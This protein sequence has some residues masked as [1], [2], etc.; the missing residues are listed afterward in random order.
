MFISTIQLL[1]AHNLN[2]KHQILWNLLKFSIDNFYNLINL[3][4]RLYSMIDLKSKKALEL[5]T[6][7]E[8][9][10][11]LCQTEHGVE[12]V[13]NIQPKNEI[14][15]V[16]KIL[17]E[18]AEMRYLLK[19]KKA[20]QLYELPDI[21]PLFKRIEQKGSYLQAQ[22]M[23]DILNV[24]KRARNIKET[25]EDEENIDPITIP[26]LLNLTSIIKPLKNLEDDIEEKI[27]PAGFVKDNASPRLSKI[28]KKMK[29]FHNE[30][31]KILEDI[32]SSNKY[33][34]IISDSNVVIRNNRFCIPIRT[35]GL[36]RI[37]G[38]VQGRSG[39]GATTFFEPYSVVQLNNS[40]LSSKED[41]KS[42]VILILISLTK[43]VRY[44]ID[45]IKNI[46]ETLTYFDFVKAKA[47]LSGDFSGTMPQL[48]ERGEI[49][50]LNARNPLL[51]LLTLKNNNDPDKEVTPVDFYL[52]GDVSTVIISGPNAGGKTVTLKTIGSMIF[53]TLCGIHIPASEGSQV[54]IPTNMLIDIGEEQSIIQS[55][56]SFTAH[57]ARLKEILDE[58]KHGSFVIIDELGIGTDPVY[59]EALSIAVVEHLSKTGS[60]NLITT[61]YDGLKTHAFQRKGMV[62][63]SVEFSQEEHRPT[64]RLIWNSFGHSHA[65]DIA[66]EMEF[67][68]NILNN[69]I[70]LIEDER[71]DLEKLISNLEDN[72]RK[73]E[74]IK[75][76]LK[77][78]SE[79]LKKEREE[80]RTKIDTIEKNRKKIEDDTNKKARDMIENLREDLKAIRKEAEK[81]DEK[82]I[83]KSLSE[84]SDL[85]KEFPQIEIEPEVDK[86]VDKIKVGDFVR[87]ESLRFEGKVIDI[88]EDKATI[89]KD[90]IT[91]E[92]ELKNLN[93][94]DIEDDKIKESGIIVKG[95]KGAKRSINLIGKTVDEALSELDAYLDAGYLQNLPSLE[96]IHG[97]G[98]GRLRNGI[99]EHLKVHPLVES[100]KRGDARSG[101]DG[102]TIVKFKDRKT[103]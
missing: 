88:K 31:Y 71:V 33:K 59:G 83:Q 86:E 53:L 25:L 64:Y 8:H 43:E 36:G 60:Y 22:D 23:L 14:S 42:E 34:S 84:L 12:L 75:T 45:D 103:R 51:Y 85:K 82:K 80:L 74:K 46:E 49:I 77:Q 66:R 78:E 13:V 94:V 29:S 55:L 4:T 7:I 17:K 89:S 102:V 21:R 11:S 10:K 68:T 30:I 81:V 47:N 90:G 79:K 76:E 26:H 6:I 15:T 16:D 28:R 65:F 1:I 37:E 99:R 58:T 35:D 48:T 20:P 5:D 32:L 44:K 98:T 93:R 50:L 27:D 39:S 70:E 57:I 61:H 101:G 41:E 40:L 92:V 38:I 9:L 54:P 97:L 63:A 62:N 56:S 52:G 95:G 19:I 100:F 72:K 96:V 24:I 87:D 3:S 91:I 69:A 18:T 2:N 67:P 73:V